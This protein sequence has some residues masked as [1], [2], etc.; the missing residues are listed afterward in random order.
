MAPGRPA[1]E[2]LR[3]D[4]EAPYEVNFEANR[5]LED[6]ARKHTAELRAAVARLEVPVLVSTA[7]TTRGPSKGV[8]E[9]AA[10]LPEAKLATIDCGHHPWLERPEETPRR[11]AH[12][13]RACP[14][15]KSPREAMARE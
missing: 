12:S 8:E 1:E 5:A 14:G 15:N 11:S 10:L 2:L 4:I 7:S 3:A 13:W 6:D 9:L